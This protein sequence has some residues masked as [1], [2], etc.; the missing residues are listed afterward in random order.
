MAETETKDKG[1]MDE[2]PEEGQDGE[3]ETTGTEDPTGEEPTEPETSEEDVEGEGD[4]FNVTGELTEDEISSL[5]EHMVDDEGNVDGKELY[6]SQRKVREVISKSDGELD[7]ILEKIENGEIKQEEET[8]EETEPTE[9]PESPDDYSLK[10]EGEEEQKEIDP[11]MEE[12]IK[13]SA[14]DAGLNNEQLNEFVN[15]F[16][17]NFE[18][19]LPEQDVEE[20]LKK[21]S[22]DEQKAREVINEQR[23]WIDGL[24]NQGFINEE[25]YE[26]LMLLGGTA[27]G[28]RALQKLRTMTK[29]DNIPDSSSSN[30]EMNSKIEKAKEMMKDPRYWPS[31]SEFDPDYRDKV[32]RMFQEVHEG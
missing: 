5:P 13:Q 28:V 23:N 3:E 7:E 14:H 15:N 8:E 19:M 6:K 29:G 10:M 21:I 11:Q 4:V 1:L 12:L 20:E 9:V 32:N 17:T 16:E 24:K 2:V 22:D 18:P 27:E 26:E 25:E 31:K 30:V